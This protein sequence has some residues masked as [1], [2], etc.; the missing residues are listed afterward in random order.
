MNN[1]CVPL[2]DVLRCVY[3]CVRIDSF[4]IF[5]GFYMLFVGHDCI[6]EVESYWQSFF[7]SVETMM[8]IG[9]GGR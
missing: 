1:Q 6:I 2:S 7:F 4:A 3:M 5:A 8:T 9:Y